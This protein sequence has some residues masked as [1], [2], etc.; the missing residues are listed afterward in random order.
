MATLLLT[1]FEPFGGDP[2]NPSGMI[3]AAL[4]GTLLPGGHLV[5]GTV[6]P[7]AGAAAYA[8]TARLIRRLQPRWIIATGVSGRAAFTPEQQAVNATDYRIPDN[9]GAQLCG[10][11]MRGPSTLYS[12]L[13]AAKLASAVATTGI[14]ASPSW[15]TG[16]Y[17]CN[18]LYYRLLH[19]TRKSEHPAHGRTTFLQMPRLAGMRGEAPPQSLESLQAAVMAV[20]RSL[21]SY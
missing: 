12:G 8:R 21:L 20:I 2:V 13:D 9:A 14:P 7:V 16:L 6:L 18:H 1:G 5:H 15:D 17:V 3:A 19:L 4:H 11:I 10:T